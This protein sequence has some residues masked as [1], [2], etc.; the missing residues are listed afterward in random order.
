MGEV[1]LRGSSAFSETRAC[2]EAVGFRGGWKPG[3]PPTPSTSVRTRV[4]LSSCRSRSNRSFPSPAPPVGRMFEDVG[5]WAHDHYP[6]NDYPVGDFVKRHGALEPLGQAEGLRDAVVR[7]YVV[8]EGVL[9]LYRCKTCGCHLELF[10]WYVVG[11]IELQQASPDGRITDRGPY[12]D[13]KKHALHTLHVYDDT[14]RTHGHARREHW[15]HG[16]LLSID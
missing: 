6:S 5:Q 8:H 4:T 3:L 7:N 2:G 12:R 9:L 13:G 1:Y 15:E 16:V 10:L 14:R 11:A